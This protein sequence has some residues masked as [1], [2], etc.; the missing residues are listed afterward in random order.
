[1]GRALVRPVDL[2]G[3]RDYLREAHAGGATM[4]AVFLHHTATRYRDYRGAATIQA[5]REYHRR[6]RGFS[7]LACHAYAAPDGL[8]WLARRLD[9]PNCACQYPQR[10]PEEWPA[11][12]RRLAQD[13]PSWCNRWAF[14]LEVIGNYDVEDPKASPAMDLGLSVVAAVMTEFGINPELLYFHRDVAYKS[15]P[16][17]RV[18][19]TWVLD[20]VVR[21]MRPNDQPSD[22]ARA[23]VERVQ[24]L[25]IMTGR[26]QSFAPR[27]PVTR[28]EL[29][30]VVERL[31]RHLAEGGER[32]GS[33]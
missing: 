22:W 18:S 19:R 8:I 4:Q 16:G 27:E 9:D 23:A 25:G 12:L 11:S 13:R 14:G 31:L 7:D 15:C 2:E 6:V 33:A 29:A 17:E 21:R 26:G 3:F 24:E 1:M 20:Q 10:P 30:V 5:F 32:N 28:E